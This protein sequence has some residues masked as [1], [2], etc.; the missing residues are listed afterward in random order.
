[1]PG[2]YPEEAHISYNRY[3]DDGD[4]VARVKWR[5]RCRQRRVKGFGPTGWRED[6]GV[7]VQSDWRASD[8]VS[9]AQ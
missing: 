1:M 5:D 3:R 4:N 7:D 8:D 6:D 9:L 2:E